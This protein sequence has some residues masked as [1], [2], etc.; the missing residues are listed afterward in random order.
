MKEI[1]PQTGTAFELKRGQILKVI[2]P[3]GQQVADLFC[4]DKSNPTDILSSGRSIDYNDSLLFT[5]G[6]RLYSYQGHVMLEILED[7]CG[8]ND[9]WVTPCSLQMFKMLDSQCEYHPSCEENL[10]KN[11]LPYN[12]QPALLGTTFNIFMTIEFDMSGKIKVQTPLSKPNDYVIF[13]AERDLIVGLTA[14]SD[15]AT[16]NGRCKPIQYQVMDDFNPEPT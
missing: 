12:F 7:S 15:E 5:K 4:F 3:Y 1:P 11:L 8:R 14:C 6:S 9:F 16:N 13:R 2:D 10:L